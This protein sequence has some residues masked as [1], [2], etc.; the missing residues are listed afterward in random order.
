MNGFFRRQ[1]FIRS[2]K[3]DARRRQCMDK[4]ESRQKK[5]LCLNDRSSHSLVAVLGLIFL[6]TPFLISEGWAYSEEDRYI[7]GYAA[8]ILE[9]E[10]GLTQYALSVDNG[11]IKMD[12]RGVPPEMKQ[13]I[14]AELNSIPGVTQV[15]FQDEVPKTGYMVGA[16]ITENSLMKSE[17]GW[18]PKD[19]LFDPLL[20][21]PRWPRFS[22]SYQNYRDNDEFD[23]IG[24]VSF[25]GRFGLYQGDGLPLGLWQLDI[26]AAVF[27]IFDLDASSYDLINSDF[28]VSFPSLSYRI[29]NF[30][31]LAQLFHQSSHLGDEYLLRDRTERINLSYEGVD[32]H[33]SYEFFNVFRIYAGGEYLFHTDPSD[34]E[35]KSYSGGIEF[36]SPVGFFN[37][38]ITPVAA[39]DFQRREE[40]RW[41]TDT[42]IRAGFEL[43][44]TSE[45]KRRYLILGESYK[46]HSPN[47]QFYTRK[48]EYLGVG[49]HIY[50]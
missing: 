10:M 12:G 28:W 16:G 7:A 48:V 45:A 2:S 5:V 18:F 38:M 23:S 15:V 1:S 21:D 26:A 4:R 37:N 22:A 36:T 8:A 19:P 11:V 46:G 13:K 49:L 9:R 24:S 3:R 34:L 27:S 35:E 25:G 20:A 32:L 50:F 44:R 41:D 33:L 31:A 29:G 39:V 40:S 43:K 42:S 17:P 47:G 14:I 30:S 6:I